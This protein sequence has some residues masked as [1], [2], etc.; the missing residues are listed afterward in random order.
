[1]TKRRYYVM[2]CIN[3]R[4]PGNPK[5]SC[6]EAGALEL[7]DRFAEVILREDLRATVRVVRTSCLD[8]CSRGP[9]MAVYPDDV[10]YQ[11]VQAA[12]VEEIVESHFKNGRPVQRLLLPP[13]EFD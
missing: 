6:T 12:D 5:G 8:N 3:E 1:M 11:R 7:R 2:L 10:W 13:D 4:P 9:T